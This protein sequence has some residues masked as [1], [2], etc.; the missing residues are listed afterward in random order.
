VNIGIGSVVTPAD[1]VNVRADIAT[2]YA[3]TEVIER[4]LH[5]SEIWFG[6]R[7]P[8]TADNFAQRWTLAPY[9]A[10]SGNNVYGT[11]LADLAQVI[12]PLDTPAQAGMEFFD[13]HRIL[14]IDMSSDTLYNVRIA[15]GTGTFNE[16]IADAQFQDFAIITGTALGNYIGGGPMDILSSRLAVGTSVWMSIWNFT[17][18]ATL[19]F[20]VGVHEYPE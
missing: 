15:W 8:Q 18:D 20:Q 13:L 19:E 4:H 6:L 3:E 9:V 1:I 11:A 12:G 10:T 7:A 16:A 14:V 2:V 5:N 17:N